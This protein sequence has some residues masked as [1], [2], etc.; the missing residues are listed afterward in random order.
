M[1][2]CISCGGGVARSYYKNK[3]QSWEN[4]FHNISFEFLG[5]KACVCFPETK[6]GKWIVRPA[7]LGAFPYVD[8]KLLKKG[9]TVAYIDETNEYGN[10]DA[11]EEFD[12]WIKYVQ[13]KYNLNSKFII[14]GF[15]RGG[16][17]SLCYAIR[18]YEKIEKIYLDAPVCDLNS[19]PRKNGHTPMLYEDAKRI[20]KHKGYNIDSLADYP[21]KHIDTLYKYKIPVLLC[22]GDSDKVV[23]F[24]ENSKRLHLPLHNSRLYKTIRKHGCGHHPH[25]LEKPDEIVDFLDSD[26]TD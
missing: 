17:F 7:F 14:E 16:F 3:Q 19:W 15:S 9:Y 24:D 20:Y 26:D 13:L 25:S 11:I 5:K 23:P 8:E 12:E 2:I 10:P 1:H 18:H 21:I 4:Q 22:Y 6:N